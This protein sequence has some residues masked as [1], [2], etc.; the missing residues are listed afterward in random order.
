[1]KDVEVKGDTDEERLNSFA[2]SLI[3]MEFLWVQ[4]SDLELVIKGRTVECLLPEEY[5]GR[6]GVSSIDEIRTE[7]V[8]L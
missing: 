1:M 8:E 4:H 2:E 3:G 5:F 6:K 7:S